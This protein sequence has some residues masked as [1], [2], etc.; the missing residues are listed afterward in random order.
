[1]KEKILLTGCAG[2]IGSNFIKKICMDPE[3]FDQYDFHIVDSLT[4][5]GHY[6]T[7][8]REIESSDHLS[9]YHQGNQKTG[10]LLICCPGHI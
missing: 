9:F 8:A 2:F 7:I 6:P 4:Y 10:S 3:N 1:M 5:A